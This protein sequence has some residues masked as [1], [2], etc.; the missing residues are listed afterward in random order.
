MKKIIVPIV[1]IVASLCAV[2]LPRKP[3]KVRAAEACTFWV[4]C[5][6]TVDGQQT[7][8]ATTASIQCTNGINHDAAGDWA[9]GRTYVPLNYC[10]GDFLTVGGT[11]TMPTNYTFGE[12]YGSG[13][14]TNSN[15]A[16][17]QNIELPA[18]ACSALYILYCRC[19]NC[20]PY[21]SNDLLAHASGCHE[22]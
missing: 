7:V 21:V 14:S 12:V 18:G 19:T 8:W 11:T 2:L 1:V 6:T 13:C 10:N 22:E 3:V 17:Y 9:A 16:A 15:R 20:L 4:T 5:G